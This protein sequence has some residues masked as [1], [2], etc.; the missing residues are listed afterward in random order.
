MPSQKGFSSFQSDNFWNTI[1]WKCFSKDNRSSLIECQSFPN[2]KDEYR[3]NN[4]VLMSLPCI[5]QVLCAT[6]YIQVNLLKILVTLV[7]RINKQ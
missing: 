2:C 4:R 1:S 3:P 6:W 5:M 7:P